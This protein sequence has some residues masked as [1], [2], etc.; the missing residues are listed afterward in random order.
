MNKTKNPQFRKRSKVT[1]KQA[2]YWPI[3]DLFDNDLE[4]RIEAEQ[5]RKLKVGGAQTEFIVD[6]QLSLQ[7]IYHLGISKRN[8]NYKAGLILVERG[9]LRRP[10]SYIRSCQ[11]LNNAET[12]EPNFVVI[13]KPK[14]NTLIQV[15]G[16]NTNTGEFIPNLEAYQTNDLKAGNY[17]KIQ[18]A[19]RFS[20]FYCPLIEKKLVSAIMHTFTQLE[21]A[22]KDMRSMIDIVK[23]R[24]KSIGRKLRGY[25][26]VLEI[27]SPNKQINAVGYHLHYHLVVIVDRL[28]I[29]G[30]K[31]PKALKL[32]EVWG[33][34]TH[35]EF[36]KTN[37]EA[38]VVGYLCKSNFRLTDT[39]G[40]KIRMFGNSRRYC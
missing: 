1:E 32:N 33:Q 21:L 10:A 9:K 35:V 6:G 34:R 37:L 8:V 2:Q 26:W 24:Y 29:K 11:L 3:I 4:G 5:R 17:R 30:G 38:L 16:L 27:S 13:T 7:R 28:N 25:F 20:K 15:S 19:K 36:V 40:K 31:M 39:N 23:C 18:S 14:W 22:G 12:S